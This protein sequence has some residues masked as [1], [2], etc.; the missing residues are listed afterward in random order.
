MVAR[1][2]E[3][4]GKLGGDGGRREDSPPRRFGKQVGMP[5]QRPPEL[6]QAVG[7]EL[8]LQGLELVVDG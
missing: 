6:Y 3:Q 8:P 5:F 7:L 2:P 1:V 4:L